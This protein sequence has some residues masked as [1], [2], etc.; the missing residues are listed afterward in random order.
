MFILPSI[1]FD[2]YN[3]ISLSFYFIFL[4]L[5]IINVRCVFVYIKY[6]IKAVYI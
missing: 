6:L 4:I 5:M 2:P 3:V 1:S